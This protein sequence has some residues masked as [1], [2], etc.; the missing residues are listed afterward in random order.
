MKTKMFFIAIAVI[1]MAGC[2]EKKATESEHEHEQEEVKFQYTV[3]TNDLNFL[4]KLT[5]W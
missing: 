1:F 2:N 3:Y 4:L 5:H